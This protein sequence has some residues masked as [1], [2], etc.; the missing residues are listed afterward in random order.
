MNL[1]SRYYET[2]LIPPVPGDIHYIEGC[3]PDLRF[4]SFADVDLD[5]V[6]QL[7][8]GHVLLDVDGTLT[9]AHGREITVSDAT[10]QKLDELCNDTRFES[11]SLATENGRYSDKLLSSLGLV[12]TIKVFQPW[13][14]GRLGT[15]WKTNDAFWK[16]ILFEIDCW[17]TPQRAVMIGDS[18][19]RDIQPAQQMG[20]KTVLLNRLESR[21][22]PL[23]EF[24][25]INRR[26]LY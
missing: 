5:Q 13:E 2:L 23:S 1:P 15:I 24:I 8:V 12:A 18:L 11:I 22:K 19:A 17:E 10:T 3:N 7:E 4:S 6:A 16:K 14:A 9:P 20:L 21:L 25:E 26:S